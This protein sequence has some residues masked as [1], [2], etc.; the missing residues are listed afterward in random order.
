[1]GRGYHMPN[2][3]IKHT[4]GHESRALTWVRG[5]ETLKMFGL[6]LGLKQKQRHRRDWGILAGKQ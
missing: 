1:M 5:V 6:D 4:S 2:A 3:R